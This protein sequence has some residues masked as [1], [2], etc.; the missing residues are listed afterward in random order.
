VNVPGVVFRRQG[1]TLDEHRGGL[2]SRLGRH[3]TLNS[4][5]VFEWLKYDDNG[6]PSPVENLER[7]GHSHGAVV[8]LDHTL[9][10]RWTVGSE[11]E[12]RHATVQNARD[13]DVQTAMGTVGFRLDERFHVTGGLGYS[14]L[15]TTAGD[16]GQSA[17]SFRINLDRG[18]SQVNWHVGYRRSFIPSFGFGGRFQNQEFQAGFMTPVTRRL[19]WSGSTAVLKADPLHGEGAALRSTWARTSLA[20][21]AN[22]FIRIEGYYT[23]VFQDTQLNGGHVNRARAGVQVSAATRKRIR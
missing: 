22:R 5:Y 23:A 11:Y 4:L 18:G 14:W 21:V 15:A 8:Q 10:T 6:V 16:P 9:N 13:F 17:P 19:E 20:Y 12:M 2:E 3:T 1:V 7:G